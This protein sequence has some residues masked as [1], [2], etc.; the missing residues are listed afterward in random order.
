MHFSIISTHPLP[1][2][3]SA[4]FSI[5]S[6]YDPESSRIKRVSTLLILLVQN[7]A[8]MTAFVAVSS[9]GVGRALTLRQNY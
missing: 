2:R 7:V 9:L 1:L 4:I 6:C 5:M 8:L 3:Y